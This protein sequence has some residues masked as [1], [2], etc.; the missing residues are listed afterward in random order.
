MVMLPDEGLSDLRPA[1]L[2]RRK[3]LPLSTAGRAAGLEI[4]P[5][6]R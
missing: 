1:G 4:R 6:W 5:V 2:A 3:N